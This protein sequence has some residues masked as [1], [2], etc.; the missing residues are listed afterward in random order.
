MMRRASFPRDRVADRLWREEGRTETGAGAEDAGCCGGEAGP[1]A[2][3][4][5]T[6]NDKP[7]IRGGSVAGNAVLLAALAAN[8]GETGEAEAE[9][10]KGGWLRNLAYSTGRDGDGIVDRYYACRIGH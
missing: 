4:G 10:G 5:C 2:H 8:R 1:A 6:K 3:A 7:A 9:K